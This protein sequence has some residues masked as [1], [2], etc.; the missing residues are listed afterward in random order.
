MMAINRTACATITQ[1]LTEA[2]VVAIL[3]TR[4]VGKTTLAR[5]VAADYSGPVHLFDLEDPADIARLAE[6]GLALRP[7]TGLVVLDEIQRLPALFPLLRVLA[8]RDPCPARFLVLGSAAPEVVRGVSE[9]LAGCVGFIQLD[10]FSLAEVGADRLDQL[11]LRGGLPPS[12]LAPDD[13]AST[14]W[15]RDFT[16]AFLERDLPQLGGRVPALTMRRFWTMLAHHHG[17]ILNA[18]KLGRGLGASD[19][20]IGRYIELLAGTYVVRVLQPW[21]ENVGKRQV[22]RPKVFIAD[23]GLLHT[24]L[25][26]TTR[27]DVERHPVL[28]ASWEGF[29]LSQVVQQLG[30]PSESCYFWATH[31][32]AELDL[33]V[34]AGNRRLGFEFKRTE[35][36]RRTRSMHAARQTL[37]LDRLDVVHAGEHTFPL[38]DGVRALALGDVRELIDVGRR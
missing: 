29:A 11:W 4:Q 37:R 31:A 12:F 6:P 10:G 35:Q 3:G 38:G 15:R 33:L 25:G 8:D 2:P 32:G 16:R 14:R 20:A 22:R 5:A 19:H 34:V 26:L 1:R 21:F 36:P 30:V 18:S 7:L 24:L 27:E 9:G 23:S 28:G 13:D 17:Q